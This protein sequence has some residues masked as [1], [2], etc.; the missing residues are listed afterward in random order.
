MRTNQDQP[1]VSVVVKCLNEAANLGRCLRSLTA[2]VLDRGYEAEIILADSI[3]TDGSVEVARGFDVTVVQLADVAD[4]RCG[5]AGHLG[6]QYARGQFLLLIDGDQELLPAFLEAALAAM[7]GDD[8][9]AAVNGGLTEMSDGIEYQERQA[10]PDPSRRPGLVDHVTGC[11]LYRTA[12]VQEAGHFMDRNLHCFEEFE[13]GLRLRARGWRLRMLDVPC[14]RHY[15]HRDASARLLLRRWRTRF[16]MGYGEL[17][18]GAWGQPYFWQALRPCRLAL[19][20]ILWW[21]VSLGLA[22]AAALGSGSVPDAL[23]AL[24]GAAALPFMALLARKRS[25][26]RAGY[27]WLML[28]LSAAALL[29]GLFLK[30]VAPAAPL[31]AV[32]LQDARAADAGRRPLWAER[33]DPNIARSE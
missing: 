32:V 17:L 13:L 29:V 23:L 9:L 22:A 20:A 28:Q 31:A 33:Q 1:L 24:A 3:S 19:L 25:L 5:A 10:R 11:A 21:G 26:E 6:W 7:R 27:A 18:R 12:A 4:R 30:R 8:R 16:L 15:G 14:I 2:E